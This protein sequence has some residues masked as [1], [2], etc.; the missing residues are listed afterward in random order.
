MY[1]LLYPLSMPNNQTLMNNTNNEHRQSNIQHQKSIIKVTNKQYKTPPCNYQ[2]QYHPIPSPISMGS[3]RDREN[4]QIERRP[5][6]FTFTG[7]GPK[8]KSCAVSS[9]DFLP[10]PPPPILYLAH[11]SDRFTPCDRVVIFC[12]IISLKCF[13]KE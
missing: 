13:R 9:A 5:S 10:L 1:F 12:N 8:R 4:L 2:Y 7:I 11:Y 3:L 6:F